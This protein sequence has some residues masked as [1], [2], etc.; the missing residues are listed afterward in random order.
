ME[1]GLGDEVVLAAG[2]LDDQ[3]LHLLETGSRARGQVL[4]RPGQGEDRRGR[5][6]QEVTS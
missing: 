1:A 2:A 5:A 4:A 3:R 6:G